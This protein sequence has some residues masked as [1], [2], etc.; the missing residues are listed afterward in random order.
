[1]KISD[2]GIEFIKQH[3]GTGGKPNRD[4]YQD[5]KGIWTIGYGHTRGVK[6]GDH[7]SDEQAEKFLQQDLKYH[8][9]RVNSLVKVPMNQNQ[10]DGLVSFHFN[11]H[12]LRVKDDDTGKVRDSGVLQAINRGDWDSAMKG[13]MM[14][15]INTKTPKGYRINDGLVNRRMAEIGLMSQPVET[16]NVPTN[17]LNNLINTPQQNQEP[18]QSN[19]NNSM[20]QGLLNKG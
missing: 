15:W 7:I 9:S 13:Q 14:Q 18:V 1:M 19:N 4:A 3:E 2:K 11:T 20:L 10:Y 12:G 5:S 17:M 6:E 16:P 8:E